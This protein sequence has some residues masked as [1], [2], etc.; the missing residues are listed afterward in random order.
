MPSSDARVGQDII[1]VIPQSR[2]SRVK[3]RNHSIVFCILVI[4]RAAS[5]LRQ[6]RLSFVTNIKN[7]ENAERER[8]GEGKTWGNIRARNARKVGRGILS[9]YRLQRELHH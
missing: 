8:T 9:R 4:V 2:G 7:W 6:Y 1:I 5:I 3:C